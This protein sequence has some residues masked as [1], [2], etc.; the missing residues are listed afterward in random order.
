MNIQRT[1]L[2]PYQCKQEVEGRERE[3]ERE[4]ERDRERERER[5]TGGRREEKSVHSGLPFP[6]PVMP[7]LTEQ[8]S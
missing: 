2:H 4:R 6:A 8:C 1:L 5:E 3:R 7:D